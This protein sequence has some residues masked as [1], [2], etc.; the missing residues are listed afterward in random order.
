MATHDP[1]FYESPKFS[2]EP[3]ELRPKQRGCFFYG[4]V[5]ASVLT[6][7]LIIALALGA[8]VFYR[9]LSRTVEQYTSPTPR[10]LPK[11]QI[12]EDH[13]KEV[14][15]R[16]KA[17][18]E[19]VKDGT[20][21]E[22]LI[23][24]GDDLNALV[25]ETPELKGK[26]FFSVEGEKIKG[27][28]SIPLSNLMD[29][30]MLRGRYLNGEAEFKASL[31]NGILVVVLDSIEVNGQHLPEEAMANLRQQNLAKD[32]TKDPDN[33]EMIRRFE[34]I[35]IKDGKII[36]K[37]RPKEPP[38]AEQDVKKSATDS[39][40]APKVEHEKGKSEAPKAEAPAPEPPKTNAKAAPAPA[41]KESS[42]LPD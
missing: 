30:G 1:E 31:S 12:S 38:K 42:E 11:V 29:I 6:V 40:P 14:M 13:R 19:G 10:E 25:E 35:E 28:V 3:D 26:V 7:L 21:S 20:A 27:K 15:D 24:T 34:S 18:R 36:I 22:P 4:C 9:F 41:A 5:I 37:P 33:A 17:F 32:I 39:K 16:F 2:P 23:L 8:F